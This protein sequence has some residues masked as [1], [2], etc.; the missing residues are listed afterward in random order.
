MTSRSGEVSE[1][2]ADGVRMP[3]NS[4]MSLHYDRPQPFCLPSSCAKESNSR[5]H[6]KGA[7][8]RGIG[9][10]SG[11]VQMNRMAEFGSGD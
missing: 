4:W 5:R 9:S 2:R 1:A 10:R 3:E 11:N 7:Q 6:V 8:Q